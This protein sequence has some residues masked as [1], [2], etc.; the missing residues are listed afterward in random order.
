MKN[1][2]F[3]TAKVTVYPFLT[4]NAR[5][6]TRKDEFNAMNPTDKGPGKFYELF[7]VHK[8]HVG[9]KAP[10]ERPIVSACGSITENIGKQDK[11][12]L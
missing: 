3:V 5:S 8:T 12:S 6:K 11:R 1:V 4:H 7:K 2:T 9:G 10:P